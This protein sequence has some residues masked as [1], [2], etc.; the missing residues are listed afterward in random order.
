[1]LMLFYSSELTLAD[2]KYWVHL[3]L[4]AQNDIHAVTVQLS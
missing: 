2:S 4:A 3:A 1:M